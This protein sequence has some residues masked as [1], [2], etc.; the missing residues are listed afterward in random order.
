MI[1]RLHSPHSCTSLLVN[2]NSPTDGSESKMRGQEEERAR[3]AIQE[4]GCLGIRGE[5]RRWVELYFC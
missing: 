2:D 3:I 4:E 5:D 1:F